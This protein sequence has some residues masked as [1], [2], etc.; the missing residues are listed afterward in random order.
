MTTD[1]IQRAFHAWRRELDLPVL[2]SLG[3][4][5]AG[6]KWATERGNGRVEELEAAIRELPETTHDAL[7]DL[8]DGINQCNC[9][10]AALRALLGKEPSDG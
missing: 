3:S 9:S 2:A 1:E 8:F 6:A 5:T 4:F 10:I 7:C